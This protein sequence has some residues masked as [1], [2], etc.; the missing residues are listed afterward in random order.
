MVI[1]IIS[2][3]SPNVPSPSHTHPKSWKIRTWPWT[4]C[5]A[6]ACGS[7]VIPVCGT[8]RGVQFPRL[9]IWKPI[10]TLKRLKT[11][12]QQHAAKHEGLSLQRSSHITKL[13]GNCLHWGE[14][15]LGET[16]PSHC[17]C[18]RNLHG[19]QS[20]VQIPASDTTPGSK[21]ARQKGWLVPN[22]P[23]PSSLALDPNSISNHHI[24][25]QV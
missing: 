14:W 12:S 3:G 16:R 2:L 1:D 18:C 8:N 19:R 22:Q 15:G 6:S 23:V 4:P 9:S 13:D 21:L 11:A 7:L 17:S 5:S 20:C 24:R 25:K 10:H